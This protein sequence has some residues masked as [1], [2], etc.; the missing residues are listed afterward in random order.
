MVK[1]HLPDGMFLLRDFESK[2]VLVLFR[3]HGTVYPIV[4]YSILSPDIRLERCAEMGR[5]TI[6]E[7]FSQ[8][9]RDI[10]QE[11]EQTSMSS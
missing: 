9:K 1:H 3:D 4:S 5:K 8:I 11:I 7:S 2:E 6:D 10:E